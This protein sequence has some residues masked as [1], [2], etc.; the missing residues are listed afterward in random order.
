MGPV[1]PFAFGPCARPLVGIRPIINEPATANANKFFLNMDTPLLLISRMMLPRASDDAGAA[2]TCHLSGSGIYQALVFRSTGPRSIGLR[3]YPPSSASCLIHRTSSLPLGRGG[4][5]PP[6]AQPLFLVT[7]R[8]RPSLSF[9]K[10]WRK[11]TMSGV[12]RLH[13]PDSNQRHRFRVRVW[14]CATGHGASA[15]SAR[16]SSRSRFA[17]R[18][19]PRHGAHRHHD[20]SAARPADRVGEKLLRCS[21][22]R[23]HT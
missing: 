5:T 14:R 11:D 16:A 4:G 9:G 8:S 7:P 17:E 15:L 22:K 6:A 23:D 2:L 1:R 13:E 20:C 10:Y 19:E 3:S 18:R 12:M 21:K